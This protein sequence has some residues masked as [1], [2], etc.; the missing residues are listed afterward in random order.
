MDGIGQLTGGIAHDFNNALMIISGCAEAMAE[1]FQEGHPQHRNVTQIVAATRGATQLARQ[2]VAFT[3]KQVVSVSVF[4]LSKLVSATAEWLPRPLG[5]HVELVVVP[6]AH[7]GMV[8][9]DSAQLEQ[10]L[11]N[12][13]VN[14]GDAMPEGG[15]LTLRTDNVEL[16]AEFVNHHPGSKQGSFVVVSVADTGCG[17]DAQ[18]QARIFEPF[19]TT[20]EMGTG[21]GLA[22]VYG[23]MKQSGGYISL[24]SWP[25]R[26][27]TFQCYLPRF[28]EERAGEGLSAPPHV[29]Q[30]GTE[31]VLLVEEDGPFR[32]LVRDFMVDLGYQV[33]SASDGEQAL[34]L[35]EGTWGP[36]HL[37]V[38]DLV[39]PPI[40]GDPLAERLAQW[41]PETRVIYLSG[42]ADQRITRKLV[43]GASL[44]RKPFELPL[45]ARAMRE[46]LDSPA[47]QNAGVQ[48][49]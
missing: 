20:K 24:E 39:V 48:N 17:M 12:L 41:H 43:A 11:I 26:G 18:T 29:R 37:M 25:G 31:S 2:L 28:R 45:L 8:R 33:L 42:Y 4:D 3:R 1:E 7:T 27:T 40:S 16:D 5:E 46:V 49:C 38:S 19:F 30:K 13:A 47:R 23:I 15:R 44:L 21:L 6:N 34:K 35:L 10:T 9:A 36:I 14:A 32:E 22:T